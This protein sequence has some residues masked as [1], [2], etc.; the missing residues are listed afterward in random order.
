MISNAIKPM[1]LQ[2]TQSGNGE[3]GIRASVSDA[4]K[5][6][7]TKGPDSLIDSGAG[8]DEASEAR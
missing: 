7:P 3:A 2:S 5:A 4:S 6:E 8:A 1:P